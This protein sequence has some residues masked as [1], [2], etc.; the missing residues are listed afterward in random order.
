M[1]QVQVYVSV[2]K[3]YSVGLEFTPSLSLW[4]LG[5]SETSGHKYTLLRSDS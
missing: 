4:S 1:Q 5:V 2:D 3:G